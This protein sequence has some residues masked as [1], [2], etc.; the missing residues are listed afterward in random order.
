[1]ELIDAGLERRAWAVLAPE[2]VHSVDSR[3]IHKKKKKKNPVQKSRGLRKKFWVL[4]QVESGKQQ[5]FHGNQMGML[6]NDLTLERKKE[7]AGVVS[8]QGVGGVGGG[9]GGGLRENER[10]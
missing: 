4:R 8:A 1:M 5:C 9:G 2:R 6:K 3:R 10:E 7:T